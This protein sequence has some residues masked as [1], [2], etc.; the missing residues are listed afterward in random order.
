MPYQK[1]VP[2][3]TM[4]TGPAPRAVAQAVAAAARAAGEFVHA[5]RHEWGA[6]DATVEAAWRSEYA[7]EVCQALVSHDPR[8]YRRGYYDGFVTAL[9]VMCRLVRCDQAAVDR[10]D[11]FTE[12]ELTAWVQA[13][14]RDPRPVEAPAFPG[15]SLTDEEG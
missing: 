5:T 6:A 15:V 11:A 10:L 7:L 4:R 8:S 14:C 1:Y 13:A 2:G 3:S 9:H 12:G